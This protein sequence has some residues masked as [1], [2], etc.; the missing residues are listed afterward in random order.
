LLLSAVYIGLGVAFGAWVLGYLGPQSGIAC[1]TGFAIEKTLAMDN[2]FVI[3]M[4]FPSRL[5]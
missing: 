2:I 1:M 4:I 5:R 3:A